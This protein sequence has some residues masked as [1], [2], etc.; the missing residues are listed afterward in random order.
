MSRVI[1]ELELKIE[2]EWRD[3]LSSEEWREVVGYQRGQQN[4][5][6]KEVRVAHIINEFGKRI[7]EEIEVKR[8]NIN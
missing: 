8:S 3:V 1:S 7:S 4:W 6:K 2:I 5:G